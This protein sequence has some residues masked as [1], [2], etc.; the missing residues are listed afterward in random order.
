MAKAYQ[1][2]LD[3]KSDITTSTFLLS[4]TEAA[5]KLSRVKYGVFSAS[6]EP[7]IEVGEGSTT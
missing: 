2:L 5:L 7:G 6:V 3:Q 4:P 1:R